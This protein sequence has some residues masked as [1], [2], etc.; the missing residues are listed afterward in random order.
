MYSSAHLDQNI[1][2]DERATVNTGGSL[3]QLMTHTDSQCRRGLG[4]KSGRDFDDEKSLAPHIFP[5]ELDT[6]FLTQKWF[7][8]PEKPVS[9]ENVAQ[10]KLSV[11]WSNR[12]FISTLPRHVAPCFLRPKAENE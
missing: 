6:N 9:I 2:E 10:E 4:T 12:K 5:T 11:N 8:V 7:F 1:H 3:H